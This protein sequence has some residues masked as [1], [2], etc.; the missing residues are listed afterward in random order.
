M[1]IIVE[2][3]H[4]WQKK[5]VIQ[6]IQYIKQWPY[7]KLKIRNHDDQYPRVSQQ[8]IVKDVLGLNP[9]VEVLE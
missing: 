1:K 4:L 2:S 7:M 8:T 6:Y 3:P 9:L 5:V